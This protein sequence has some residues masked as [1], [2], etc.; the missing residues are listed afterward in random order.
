M[1]QFRPL[2]SGSHGS[3]DHVVGKTFTDR[4]PSRA[5]SWFSRLFPWSPMAPMD[6]ARKL[7]RIS[8]SFSS[9]EASLSFYSGWKSS[10]ITDFPTYAGCILGQTST[11]EWHLLPPNDFR[12]WREVSP[13]GVKG[14]GWWSWSSILTDFHHG[15]QSTSQKWGC[16]QKTMA[17]GRF[18]VQPVFDS[19]PQMGALL[20]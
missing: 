15:S 3:E 6:S 8:G 7:N 11:S 4:S 12:A 16:T 17:F 20:C 10:K 13:Q 14:L 1:N 18:W 19:D 9:S 2:T 5:I